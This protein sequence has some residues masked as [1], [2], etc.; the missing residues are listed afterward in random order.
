[1]KTSDR[2]D[3]SQ[4]H[5][6]VKLTDLRTHEGKVSKIIG[7]TVEVTGLIC[8]IGDICL[9]RIDKHN[10][11]VMSEV[12]GIRENRALLMPLPSTAGNGY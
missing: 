8:S 6:I 5:Q 12:V 1:M 7:M 4:F 3:M 9:I 2:L 11:T 10:Q